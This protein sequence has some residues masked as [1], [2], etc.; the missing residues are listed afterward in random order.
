MGKD[1]L[2]NFVHSDLLRKHILPG[3]PSLS[4]S[5]RKEMWEN[6]EKRTISCPHCYS[7][8]W[9]WCAVAS[10]LVLAVGSWF[11]F[12]KNLQSDFYSRMTEL[13]DVD[14]LHH[15]S[16]FL[17]EQQVV[18]D[19][20]VE[21]RCVAETNQVEV[22]SINGT[23]FK[24]SVTE[25]EKGYLQ[26]AVPVG[27]K[28]D[29]ILADKS[30]I[31]VR[32]QSKLCFPLH[33]A[34]EKRKVY[35]EGEAYLKVTPDANKRFV[36]ETPNMNVGVLGTEFLISAYPKALEQS[37]LLISGKV[38]VE[39]VR[40]SRHVLSPNQRYVFDSSTQKSS[41]NSDVD[42]TIYICWKENLLKIEDEPLSCVL[43]KLEDIYNTNFN[44]DWNELAKIHINGKLDISVPLDELLDRLTKIAPVKLDGTQRKVILI[45]KH[46]K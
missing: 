38:E 7:W 16:L 11:F 24:L 28:A 10:V 3:E 23:S 19:S 6:I 37:V 34:E 26:L 8:P 13:V 36:T 41:L 43:K 21:V 2:G 32:E 35:L 15:I 5:E 27:A 33:F 1:T 31:T 22:K 14:T 29:V 42:P 12:Q 4:E 20:Q 46:K 9:R 17:G 30:R 45:D 44:Y 18:F 25:Q 39:S 40:G